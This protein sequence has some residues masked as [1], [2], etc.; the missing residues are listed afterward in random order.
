MASDVVEVISI[1]HEAID[2]DEPSYVQAQ[3]VFHALDARGWI[4]YG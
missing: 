3:A 4:A 2:P 1:I